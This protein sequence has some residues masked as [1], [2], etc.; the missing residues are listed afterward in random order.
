VQAAKAME[1]V[2][3]YRK[4]ARFGLEKYDLGARK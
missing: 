2:P 3:E 4:Q 1:R